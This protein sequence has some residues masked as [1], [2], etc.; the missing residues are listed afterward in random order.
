MSRILVVADT[1]HSALR[2]A[3]SAG[4]QM[5]QWVYLDDL[6][7]MQGIRKGSLWLTGNYGHNPLIGEIMFEA[8]MRDLDIIAVTV[9]NETY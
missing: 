1:M 6:K 5:N 7:K 3:H 4:L 8:R 9:V 2:L